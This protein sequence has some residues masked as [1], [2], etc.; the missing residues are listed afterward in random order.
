M[1]KPK[2][3]ISTG[4]EVEVVDEADRLVREISQKGGDL[5][6]AYAAL[7]KAL[8]S[9]EDLGY[10]AES[11][12][13][14]E[15]EEGLGFALEQVRS[16]KGFWDIYSRVLRKSLCNPEGDLRQL[17][18]S[19]IT[20][21]THSLASAVLASLALPVAAIPFAASLVAIIAISGLDSFCEWTSNEKEAGP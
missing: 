15:S 7:E 10:S 16:G 20:V 6:P 14:A 21:T 17:V 9:L 13:P 2:S 4:S 3:E 18:Q 1:E 5:S 12:L 19:G 8:Q 11:L